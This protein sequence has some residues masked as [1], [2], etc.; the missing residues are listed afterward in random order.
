MCRLN[1]NGPNLRLIVN[2]VIKVCI[3]AG[4]ME[5]EQVSEGGTTGVRLYRTC[6]SRRRRRRR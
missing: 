4:V 2:C 1:N 3:D 5:V 6:R